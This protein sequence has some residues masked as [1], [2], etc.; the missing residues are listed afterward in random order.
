VQK[1]SFRFGANGGLT[2][3][4]G[5]LIVTASALIAGDL[6]SHAERVVA[7]VSSNCRLGPGNLEGGPLFLI[8]S[9]FTDRELSNLAKLAVHAANGAF[10]AEEAKLSKLR[11]IL[12]LPQPV[13]EQFLVIAGQQDFATEKLADKLVEMSQAH[14]VLIG[15]L[16]APPAPAQPEPPMKDAREAAQ[17]GRYDDTQTMLTKASVAAE[18]EAQ[19]APAMSA[20]NFSLAASA[21]AGLGQIALIRSEYREAAIYFEA[22]LRLLADSDAARQYAYSEARAQALYLQGRDKDDAGALKDAIE[23]YRAL[24]NAAP[25]SGGPARS[26]TLQLNLGNALLRL[27]ARTGEMQPLQEAL[28]VFRNALQEFQRARQPLD[29]ARAQHGI[30]ATLLR[31]GLAET[32]TARLQEAVTAFQES[33]KEF[34]RTRAPLEWAMAQGSLGTALWSLGSRETGFARFEASVAAYREGLKQISRDHTPLEWATRQ[35]NLGAALVSLSERRSSLKN[36]QEAVTAFRNSLEAYQDE[37]AT[38]YI[39]GVKDNLDRAERMLKQFRATG[40]MP[41]EK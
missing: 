39:G 20:K 8:H 24:L 31:L 10:R 23:R 5:T 40:K 7:P 1:K 41:T 13:V 25:A 4:A 38:Y 26:A 21:R 28:I 11:T 27:G 36:L 34:T 3:I 37:S 14:K 12:D 35:N 33:L 18:T 17:A 29:W 16:L 19:N 30:G 6:P 2:R 9:C 15:D 32:G 22:A